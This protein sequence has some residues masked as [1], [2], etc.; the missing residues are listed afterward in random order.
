MSGVTDHSLLFLFSGPST[1]ATFAAVYALFG[2]TFPGIYDK[3][4][5]IYTLFYPVRHDKLLWLFSLFS[6]SLSVGGFALLTSFCRVYPLHSLFPASIQICS[7][8]GK[9]FYL[10]ASFNCECSISTHIFLTSYLTSLILSQWQIC[11]S[12]S[13]MEQP[14]SHAE[15]LYL[16]AQPIARL[17][18]DH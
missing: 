17:V 5:G 4:R 9:V 11:P 16:I 6:F 10:T 15:F 2:P 7:Q 13:Q 8:T 18:L 14:L 1:L 12:S 3:E